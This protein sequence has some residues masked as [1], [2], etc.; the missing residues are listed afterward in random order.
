MKNTFTMTSEQLTQKY[1]PILSVASAAIFALLATFLAGIVSSDI[2]ATL[3]RW[4]L[5]LPLRE[6]INLAIIIGFYLLWL[7]LAKKPFGNGEFNGPIKFGNLKSFIIGAVVCALI[8]GLSWGSLL[9]TNHIESS[10]KPKEIGNALLV[11]SLIYS[12]FF[13]L[14]HGLAEQFLLGVIAQNYAI[15]KL[16]Y[17][18][19]II[20]GAT[21]F[22]LLQTLQGYQTIGLMLS[23]FAIGLVLAILAQKYGVLAAASLHGFWTWFEVSVLPQFFAIKLKSNI[24]AAGG[25]D[26]YG[27]MAFTIISFIVAL[28]LYWGLGVSKTLLYKS[29]NDKI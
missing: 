6:P 25:T 1:N 27:S 23:S 20:I 18:G 5:N 8:L 2:S 7:K 10:A 29:N 24:F 4:G 21:L 16:G 11:I 14:L 13:V 17:F 28:V 12:L 3:I 15:G 9:V 19:G 22:L 26:T